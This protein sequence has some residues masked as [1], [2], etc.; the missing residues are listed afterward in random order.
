M[1]FTERAKTLV[2]LCNDCLE[3][4]QSDGLGARLPKA[5]S[6]ERLEVM[7]QRRLDA[8]HPLPKDSRWYGTKIM[9][10]LDDGSTI[11]GTGW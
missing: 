10:D 4:I 3:Q 7:I 5:T 8:E 9:R 11:I 2:P 1:T 6:N